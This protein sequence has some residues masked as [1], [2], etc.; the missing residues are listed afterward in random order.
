MFLYTFRRAPDEGHSITGSSASGCLCDMPFFSDTSLDGVFTELD[1]RLREAGSALVTTR[2]TLTTQN[3][4]QPSHKVFLGS[5]LGQEPVSVS[6]CPALGHSERLV[7]ANTSG[8]NTSARCLASATRRPQRRTHSLRSTILRLLLE[9]W[10]P[11]IAGRASPMLAVL[12][13]NPVL[14]EHCPYY[15]IT[16]RSTSADADLGSSENT[17]GTHRRYLGRWLIRNHK[18]RTRAT[19]GC[20]V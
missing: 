20:P 13:R 1:G 2:A 11:Q 17:A 8:S 14:P 12:G 3:S 19:A 5:A 9:S 18:A 6:R 16:V 10:E 7:P 4:P 15:K